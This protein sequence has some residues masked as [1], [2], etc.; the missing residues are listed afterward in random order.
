MVVGGGPAGLTAALVLGRARRRVVVVDDRTYRNARVREFHGFPGRDAQD[1]RVL[2]SDVH[3][4]LERYGVGI[5]FTAVRSVGPSGTRVGVRLADGTALTADR[6]VLATGVADELPAVEGLIERWG[7]SAFNCPFCDGWEHR[8]RP[9]VV[10][11]AAPGAD[12]LA[13]MLRSWTD[14]VTVVPVADVRRLVGPPGGL[15]GIELADGSV[16]PADGVFVR[17]PL[18]PRSGLAAEMGCALDDG[19]FV[20]ADDTG[21]TSNPAVW[22]AGDLRRPPPLPHQVVLAAADGANA[23]IAIHKSLL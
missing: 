14:D 20:V 9:V 2:R 8:D 22:A 21:L 5:R 19:G 16:L 6:L 1:P 12:H 4:E 7:L 13:T 10:L 3:W 18:R 23:A 17:A 11:D 15:D